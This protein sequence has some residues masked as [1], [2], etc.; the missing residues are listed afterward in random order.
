MGP[1]GLPFELLEP[2]PAERPQLKKICAVR[3]AERSDI[4]ALC[5]GG[6]P[7][8]PFAFGGGAPTELLLG[9]ARPPQGELRL[10]FRV[11]P[12]Q[13]PGTQ[14][15][16]RRLPPAQDPRLGIRRRGRSLPRSDGT[17]ALS[18]SGAVTLPASPGVACG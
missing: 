9:L 7:F 11:D 10:W 17:W 18:W 12:P 3:G 8:K 4:T 14:P 13:G 15:P 5:A 6:T 16:R 1:H 2:V